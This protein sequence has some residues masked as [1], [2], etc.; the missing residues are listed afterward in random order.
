MKKLLLLGTSLVSTE[1]VKTAREMGYHTIVTDYLPPERSYAKLEADEYWMISTDEIDRLEKKC[2]EAH[3]DAIFSGVSEFNLDRV[4]ELT[5]RLDLPCYIEDKTWKYA[6]NKQK[7]KEKCRQIGIPTADD[8][9]LSN[10]PLREEME[11]LEYPVV[12]KP[13]DGNGN[14]GLSICHDERELI[15]AIEKAREA[16]DSSSILT[17]KYIAGEESWNIYYIAENE[18]R[19]VSRGRAFKQPGYPTF[20]YPIC[21]SAMEDNCEFKEQ[22]D[23]K[24]IELLKNIGCRKGIAWIQLIRDE[25]GKYFALEMAQRL[26]AGTTGIF[27]EK[28]HGF[29]SVRWALNTAFGIRQ[30]ALTIPLLDKPPYRSANCVYFLFADRSGS[31]S[32]MKGF[33]E[34]DKDRFLVSNV[35]MEGD[36]IGKYRLISRIAFNMK[37]GED[38]C[39]T[40]RL[41]N[42]KISIL[43]ENGEN[44]YIRYT[45]FNVLM[46]KLKGLF[47]TD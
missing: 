36:Y 6:R 29:N 41:I 40:L 47:L 1:I 39:D 38:L 25:R 32:S 43:D 15:E 33:N 12:V 9:I 42:E 27:A 11:T 13:I 19:C 20:L 10:P 28:A 2:R 22:M 17:E 46:E 14:K 7:F 24:C 31:I 16:S 23:E 26:S 30:T 37:N 18:Y 3:I 34:L 5:E 4:K 44:M 45:D 8:Y 35:A 21:L